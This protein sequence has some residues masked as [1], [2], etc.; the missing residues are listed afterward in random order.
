MPKSK[1]QKTKIENKEYLNKKKSRK[2]DNEID[3]NEINNQKNKIINNKEKSEKLIE[4][5]EENFRIIEPYRTLGLIID[6]NKIQFSKRGLERFI[7]GSNGNSFLLYNLEKLRLER[8]SPPME[9]KISSLGFYKNKILTGIGNKVQLWD[10]IHIIKEFNG[11][12]NLNCEIKQIMTFE[13]VLI[14]SCSNGELFIYTIESNELISHLELRIDIFIHPTTYLNRIL[15]NKI[16]EK[17]END[18]NKY[19]ND[20][21]LYNINSEKE[22]YNFKNELDNKSK[23]TIIEQSPVI[24]II[25]LFFSNGEILLFNMKT[26]KKIM[27]LKSENKV[28]S[29]TFSSCLTMNHSLLITSCHNGNINIWDLNKKSIHYSITN[30]FSYIDNVF[31][32]PNEPILLCT[33]GIDNSIKMYKFD[34]ITSIPQL[35]KMRNGHSNSPKIIKF[36]GNSNNENTQILSC[37]D[38]YLRNISIINEHQ[39]REFSYKKFPDLNNKKIHKIISFDYNEF[40]ERDW[41]N[42]A[43][44]LSDYNKPILLSYENNS[45][46]K[47]QPNLKTQ[48][49]KCLCISISICG[50]FGFCGFE[51]GNIEKF[52]MQSGK[53]KWVI[54]NCHG[55]LKSV[56][57]LKSDG[58]NSMLISISKM[59]KKIKFWEILQHN[60]IDYIDVDNYP[61]KIEIN[62]D[63]DLIGV[64]FD[65]NYIN[66][67][68]KSQIKLVR[69]FKINDF[70]DYSISDFNFSNDAKWLLVITKNDKSLK[71]FDILSSNLIEWVDFEKIPLSVSISNDNQYISLSF[72]NDNGIYLYINKTLFVDYEDITNIKKPIHCSLSVFK[73]KLIKNRKDF[74]FNNQEMKEIKGVIEEEKEIPKENLNLISFSNENNLKY[75]II[76]NIEEIQEKNT[77]EIEEK[78]KEKA[79]FFLFNIDDVIQGKLPLKKG[80][81]KNNLNDEENNPEYINLIKN[82]S[83]FKNERMINEKRIKSGKL[84]K[85]EDD[86]FILKKLLNG[87]NN[88]KIYSKEITQFLNKLNPYIVDLEIR[89]ID[90][91]LVIDN[92]DYLLLFSEYLFEEFNNSNSNYEMLQAYLNRFIKIFN[93]EIISNQNIKDNLNKINEL[94]E[95]K[96]KNLEN[97]YKDTICLISFFGKIQI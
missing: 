55:Y 45:I 60:L 81:N 30:N 62:R 10:K 64:S 54:I 80:N 31:F 46:S 44:V 77:P 43:L 18:L 66:I 2:E 29:M 13:N 61:Q 37:D 84:N 7:L 87:F 20:L 34:N 97:M 40:R 63:N 73:V 27:S 93:E 82:Y 83:H 36:Y 33:S 59:E 72:E 25:G 71:I 85:D 95:K 48:N 92:I 21:I 23:I 57:D 42:I 6:K 24:D 53:S 28:T 74:D 35:L 56:D 17:Y 67:Y 58:I 8:I 22:I 1:K 15:Y 16:S 86:G 4:N 39:S 9:K 32:I 5:T 52:N 11:C 78:Q 49:S 47:N 14:F 79:P 76:N 68:D 65:N 3:N 69:N 94:N 89:S 70:N 50:N 91:M 38:F 90:P 19:E 12:N 88:K 75:K 96:F 26:T 41:S 51:N